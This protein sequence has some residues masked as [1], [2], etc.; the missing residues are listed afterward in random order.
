MVPALLYNKCQVGH[1][2]YEWV[3]FEFNN[4]A[5]YTKNMILSGDGYQ[6]IYIYNIFHDMFF[7]IYIVI[8]VICFVF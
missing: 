7:Y 3:K 1:H 6:L 8:K 2:Y 5:L 4:M